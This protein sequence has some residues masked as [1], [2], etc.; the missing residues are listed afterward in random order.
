M[1]GTIVI[2][3]LTSFASTS[4]TAMKKIWDPVWKALTFSI[5][6]DL[7]YPAKAVSASLEKGMLSVAYGSRVFSHIKIKDIREYNFE[8]GRYPQAEAFAS[9]LSLAISDLGASR[10]EITLSIPK[11]W[12]VIKTAEFPATTK[13][14]LSNVVSYELDRITPFTSENA[15]YDFKIVGENEGKLTIMVIAAKA[16]MIKPY[17]EALSEKGI[18][19]SRVTVNLS[20]IETLCRYIDRKTDSVFIEI[21]KI[22]FASCFAAAYNS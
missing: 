20:G 8:E 12:A 9:S 14:N 5:A 11:A 22:L 13:E 3:K 2:H 1:N 21:K 10:A 18:A 16:D 19:V 4:S 17:I 6:D 7:I 15:F